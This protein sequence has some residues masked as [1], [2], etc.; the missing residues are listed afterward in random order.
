MRYWP[1]SSRLAAPVR[2][3]AASG[4]VAD[5]LRDV[6]RQSAATNIAETTAAGFFMSVLPP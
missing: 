6:T 5:A 1:A 3:V 4:M 2:V